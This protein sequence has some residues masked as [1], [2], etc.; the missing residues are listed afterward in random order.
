MKKRKL[1]APLQPARL[2][3][4][5]S[6]RAALGRALVLIGAAL[7][8]IG[9]AVTTALTFDIQSKKDWRGILVG[10]GG[11]AAMTF[12]LWVLTPLDPLLTPWI[13]LDAERLVYFTA[14]KRGFSASRL[15]NRGACILSVRKR[16]LLIEL[17]GQ[18]LRLPRWFRDAHGNRATL[19]VVEDRL[20]TIA[21]K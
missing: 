8:M 17:D 11:L 15:R 9:G 18:R 16:R 2:D 6:R 1:R 4:D 5:H 3:N 20:D 10:I 21:A 19:V 13:E 7:V 14:A 12:Y